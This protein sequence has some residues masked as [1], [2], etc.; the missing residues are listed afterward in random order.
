MRRMYSLNQLKEIAD[1]RIQAL[2]EGGT[3]ENA[4][5]LYFHP[6]VVNDSVNKVSIALIIIDNVSTPYNTWS[7]VKA[8]MLS[9]AHEINDTARFPATGSFYSDTSLKVNRNID[10]KTDDTLVL[11]GQ[12]PS[13]D[14]AS[15]TI[16]SLTAEVFDGVNKIN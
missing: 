3:L 8:K 14:N 11:Y 2:V 5:P 12:D 13:G 1:A 9:I 10:A 6:I 7:K 15:T 4:K 16:T